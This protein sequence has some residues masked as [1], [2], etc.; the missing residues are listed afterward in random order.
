MGRV[1]LDLLSQ[2]CHQHPQMFRLVDRIRPPHGFQDCAMREYSIRTARQEREQLEFLGRKTNF[3]VSSHDTVPVVIDGQ[4]TRLQT[5]GW[6]FVD[7]KYS[8]KSDTD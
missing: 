5:A 1:G 4:V 6:R 7:R 3:V 8:P 2:L